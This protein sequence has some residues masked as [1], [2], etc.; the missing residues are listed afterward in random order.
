MSLVEIV[1][2]RTSAPDGQSVRAFALDA[3][4][5]GVTT[6]GD[7]FELTGWVLGSNDRVTAVEVVADGEVI[8]SLRI[9]RRRD[10]VARDYPDAPAPEQSGFRG[11]VPTIALGA[12]F[13]LQAR[14][15]LA[16]AR[17]IPLATIAGRRVPE[18]R[19]SISRSAAEEHPRS[20]GM[21]DFVIVGTQRG[22][23]TSL[24]NNLIAH[25]KIAP[26]K[27]KEVHFFSL[28]FDRGL[29]WYRAQFPTD[30]PPG[31][32]TGESSPYYLFHPLAPQRM[33]ACVPHAKLIVLL[34]NPVDRAYSHYHLEL[35]RGDETLPF[36]EAIAHEEERLRGEVDRLLADD[37][38]ESFAHQ[39]H[40]YLA[41]GRYL[42][43]LRAWLNLFPREQLLILKSEDLYHHPTDVVRQATDFLGLPPVSL[44]DRRA[45]NEVAYLK[46]RDG[47]RA[48]LTADFADKNRELGEYLGQDFGWR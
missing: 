9:A 25:P 28:F 37:T 34:R 5:S 23:T 39:H 22:G 18:M 31:T 33:R 45:Y 24:Y 44:T 27:R 38:Y 41:R 46:M 10:D 43:Q 47:T 19:R 3:P 11:W 20:S 35:S 2:V 14:A 6:A 21:P 40:S 15:V 16:G 12:T 1:D 8:S 7:G 32:I 13:E 4:R 29:A 17:S 36:E 42:D 48:R 30:L 26:A